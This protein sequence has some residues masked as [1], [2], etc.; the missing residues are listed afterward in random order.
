MRGFTGP[1][2]AL[3]VLV[4]VLIGLFAATQT[5]YFLGTNNRGF[6]TVYRGLPIDLPANVH[7]YST[8]FVSGV[9][10]SMLPPTRRHELLDHSLRSRSDA[11]DLIRRVELGQVSG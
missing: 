11:V 7:L 1:L 10:A 8:E 6:V 4:L 5:V 2:V 3:A 9:P